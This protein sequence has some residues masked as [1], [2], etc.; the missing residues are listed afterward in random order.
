[1]K[2][3]VRK[4]AMKMKKRI[5]WITTL[6]FLFLAL[7]LLPVQASSISDEQ[8]SQPTMVSAKVSPEGK[9]EV[10]WTT[11]GTDHGCYAIYRKSGT[12]AFRIIDFVRA[13]N[14]TSYSYTDNTVYGDATYT[15]SVAAI[16]LDNMEC[17]G[18]SQHSEYDIRACTVSI[19]LSWDEPFTDGTVFQYLILADDKVVGIAE[20]S[21]TSCSFTDDCNYSDGE[22]VSVYDV[23]AVMQGGWS[24]YDPIGVSVTVNLPKTNVTSTKLVA[25]KTIRINWK[26]VPAAT[27]YRIYRRT[28][29]S[30]KW[31][32]IADIKD[33]NQIYCYDTSVSAKKTYYYTVKAY[34]MEEGKIRYSHYN[35]TGKKVKY[36]SVKVNAKKGNYKKGSV[37]GPQLSTV[38]LSQV[39]K[40][41]QSFHK[42]YI[43][44]DMSDLEKVLTAQLYMAYTCRYAETYSKNEANSA[45][46]ALVYKNSSGKHE[47]QCSGYARGFKAL[48]D[49]MGVPCKYVHA[50]SGAAK[51][52]HQWVQVK[53][54][55]KWY[56]IDPACNTKED[57]WMFLI[58]GETYKTFWSM[59]G[60]MSWKKSDYPSLSSKD[61]PASEVYKTMNNYKMARVI[62][63]LKKLK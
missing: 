4:D 53:I 2:F 39:K 43:T 54:K 59:A 55:K 12:D 25:D 61:Y 29:K 51:G 21:K 7:F 33:I 41:V 6:S 26:K 40:A 3:F 8:L 37:Y 48:C 44:S 18:T 28:K 22:R 32:Q 60:G 9:V 16:P 34:V 42:K 52:S 19:K 62:K 47:A 63:K 36:S 17:C 11:D 5:K 14:K 46:G 23:Y 24:S 1:M 35:K 49:G 31:K 56:I 38:K 50:T 13:K 30:G 57:L 27:G 15:Y 20:N 58:S 45:W 10:Q